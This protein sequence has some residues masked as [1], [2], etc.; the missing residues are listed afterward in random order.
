MLY[1]SLSKLSSFC[2]IKSKTTTQNILKSLVEKGA[3]IKVEEYHNGVKSCNY[4]VNPNWHGISKFDMGISK[5][6]MGVYQKLI[7]IIKI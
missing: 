4:S 5:I 6:D 1:G 3:I 7:L 2:G